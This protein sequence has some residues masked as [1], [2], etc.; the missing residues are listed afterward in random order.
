MPLG[1]NKIWSLYDAIIKTFSFLNLFRSYFVI[2]F[3]LILLEPVLFVNT[4]RLQLIQL[5]HYFGSILSLI[6]AFSVCEY[7]FTVPIFTLRYMSGFFC[8]THTDTVTVLFTVHL[9]LLS[10][11]YSHFHVCV[12]LKF[13]NEGLIKVYLIK[14]LNNPPAMM[15][16]SVTGYH[17]YTLTHLFTPGHNLS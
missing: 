9:L 5:K 16:L 17:A 2:P 6:S 13:T 10:Q 8:S 15:L 1:N 4:F 7:F 11:T 14:T 3:P 12:P